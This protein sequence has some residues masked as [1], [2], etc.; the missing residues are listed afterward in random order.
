MVETPAD[1]FVGKLAGIELI[2]AIGLQCL[3]A[4]VLLGVA[5]IVLVAATRRVVVQDGASMNAAEALHRPPHV[6]RRPLDYVSLYWHLVRAQA[7]GQLRYKVSFLLLVV[8]STLNV[9]VDLGEILVFFRFIR[10]LAGWS[11]AEVAMLYGFSSFSFAFAEALAMGFDQFHRNVVHGTFDRVLV[12]PLG[13]FFQIFASDLG[14]RRVGRIAQ[15]A[16]VLAIAIGALDAAWSLD[17]WLVFALT[18]LSGTAIF[19]GFFVIGAASSFWTIQ[20]NEAINIFTHGGS[21]VTAYPADVFAG[22]LRRL[23]T[24]VVPLAFINYYPALYLLDRPD[25]LGLPDA[26][27][28]FSPL[29]AL[30][31]G[32]VARATWVHGVRHYQSTGT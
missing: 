5:R 8:G 11:L 20:A 15:A 6:P 12:R 30:L 29:A 26:V 1:I 31:V 27:R 9:I 17:K 3:W 7:R 23:M 24:F 25:P 13:A 28:L 22:W 19:F 2:G 21:F 32:L 16:V 10:T 4:V 18:L 14:V